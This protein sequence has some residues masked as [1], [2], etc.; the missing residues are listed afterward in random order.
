MNLPKTIRNFLINKKN[1]SWLIALS[2]TIAVCQYVVY[3]LI[4]HESGKQMLGVWSLV[5]AA[6]SIGQI[7]NFGFG[8]SLVRYLPEL[9]LEKDQAGVQRMIGTVNISCFLLVLP[10]LV[11]LYFPAVYYGKLLLTPDQFA[12]FQPLIIFSLAALFLNSLFLVYSF[13]FDA[14][15]KHYLRCK[16]QMTGWLL[17]LIISYFLLPRLGLKGV[18]TAMVM[19]QIFQFVAIM[20]LTSRMNIL[21]KPY[22]L[23]PDKTSLKKI[24]SF[25]I[26]SQSINILVIFFDPLIKFFITSNLGLSATGTYEIANK[27][28]IQFRNLLVSANQVIIPKMVIFQGDARSAY[29]KKAASVNLFLSVSEGV[30]LCVIAPVAAYIFS[31]GMDR[32]VV[33]CILL[34]N[35]GWTFNAVTSVHYYSAIGMDKINRLVISHLIQVLVVLGLYLFLQNK[36]SNILLFF[37]VPPVALFAES[38]YNSFFLKKN[39]KGTF[40]WLRSRLLIYFLIGSIAVM[41]SFEFS[42]NLFIMLLF[43][44]VI[45][46]IYY[47]VSQIKRIRFSDLFKI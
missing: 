30:L 47:A 42:T 35:I 21:N 7:S 25:G 18:A 16:I 36:S 2:I 13:T 15:Q 37:A 14:L 9:F 33:E 46:Y 40:S 12:V 44:F 34:L 20:H 32:V 8:N 24:Y 31:S 3:T 1:V 11:L 27:I 6:T 10:V 28:S 23:V 19:Q 45:F 41:W 26:H 4:N 38:I 29:F 5:I 22:P 43:A 39:L 17:F